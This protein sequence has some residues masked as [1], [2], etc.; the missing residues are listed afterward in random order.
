[1]KEN[2]TE[3]IIAT[4]ADRYNTTSKA[5]RADI[6]SALRAACPADP[7]QKE[8]IA[9]VEDVLLYAAARVLLGK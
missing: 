4:I 3:K 7:L 6:E 1:M 8:E 2:W 5:V 9:N